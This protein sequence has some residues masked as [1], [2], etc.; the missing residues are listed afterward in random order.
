MFDA[1]ALSNDP[2]TGRYIAGSLESANDADWFLVNLTEG[3]RVTFHIGDNVADTILRL[4]DTATG[5]KDITDASKRWLRMDDDWGWEAGASHIQF[6][7]PLAGDYYLRV[8]GKDGSTGRYTLWVQ[9]MDNS[10]PAL[11]AWR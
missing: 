5:Y 8:T 7:S 3:E 2:R 6:T 9:R 4:S 10:A 1:L 11:P